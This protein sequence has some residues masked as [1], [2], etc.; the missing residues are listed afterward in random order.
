VVIERR[1]PSPIAAAL[2]VAF[3]PLQRGRPLLAR[4]SRIA[5]SRSWR[6]RAVAVESF[7]PMHPHPEQPVT[8]ADDTADAWGLPVALEE[9]PFLLAGT[10]RMGPPATAACDAQGR[11]HGLD[12]VYVCDAG[13]L[14]GIG[15]VPPTLTIMAN[16]LRIADAIR[17]A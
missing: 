17:P 3:D 2:S 14:P 10:L 1:P 9:T 11:L 5:C 7:L 8:L 4:R 16:A 15:G 6:R 12:N 13:A